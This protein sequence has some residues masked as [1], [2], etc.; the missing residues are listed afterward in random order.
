MPTTKARKGDLCAYSR[1]RSSTSQA[2]ATEHVDWYLGLVTTASREGAVRTVRELGYGTLHKREHIIELRI[3]AARLVADLDG[4]TDAY[5]DRF[6][7][8]NYAAAG[9]FAD[10][11]AAA[12]FVLPYTTAQV[13]PPTPPGS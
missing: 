5:L 7:R 8:E 6:T 9:P 11:K 1:R 3:V 2:G 13:Q 10:A 4:L 12:T